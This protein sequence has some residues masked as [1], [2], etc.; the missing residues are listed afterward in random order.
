MA[1]KGIL[2]GGGRGTSGLAGGKARVGIRVL[3]S[4]TAKPGIRS[5]FLVR[6]DG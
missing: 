4:T 1:D 3:E 5:L 6:F 2:V